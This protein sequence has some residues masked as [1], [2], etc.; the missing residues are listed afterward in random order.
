[1]KND[2]LDMISSI[3][4]GQEFSV[5]PY[6]KG[7]VREPGYY[8]N[9][10]NLTV[11]HFSKPCAYNEI[12]AKHATNEHG[13]VLDGFQSITGCDDADSFLEIMKNWNKHLKRYGVIQ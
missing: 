10:K 5:L 1:M 8:F 3:L 4:S 13:L 7:G 9:Q 12:I 11:E 6:P 2:P